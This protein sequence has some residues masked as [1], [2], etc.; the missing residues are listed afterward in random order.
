MNTV[1]NNHGFSLI[2]LMVV[3]AIISV[4]TGIAGFVYVTRLPEMRLDNAARDLM[5]DIRQTRALAVEANSPYLL[6]IT[7]S[8]TYQID[9][10]TDS[11]ATNCSSDGTPTVRTTDLAVDYPGVTFGY[12][13]GLKDCTNNTDTI[14]DAVA[15]SGNNLI[16]NGAGSSVLSAQPGAVPQTLGMIYLTNN[17]GDDHPTRCLSVRG[18]IGLVKYAKWSGSSWEG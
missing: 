9:R 14:D 8:T 11:S 4:M 6:C 17:D 7:S 1:D 3:L 10:V 2:E 12:K 18:M 15:L 16:F 5:G 13:S